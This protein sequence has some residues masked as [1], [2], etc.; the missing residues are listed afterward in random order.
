M[1]HSEI[2][3]SNLTQEQ[4]AENFAIAKEKW[5]NMLDGRS[6]SEYEDDLENNAIEKIKAYNN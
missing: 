3:G 1:K 6:L 2:V 5:L 4:I